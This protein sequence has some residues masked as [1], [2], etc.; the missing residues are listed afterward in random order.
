MFV[1]HLRVQRHAHSLSLSEVPLVVGMA[2]MAPA[3]LLLAQTLGVGM[4]LGFH[5]RQRAFRLA[6]NLAQRFSTTVFAI[7]AFHGVLSFGDSSWGVVWIAGIMAVLLA[8]GLAGVLINTG[9]VLAEGD[10]LKRSER[11]STLFDGVVGVGTVFALANAALGLLTTMMIAEHPSGVLL[12]LSPAATTFL[13]GRAYSKVQRQHDDLTRL[14]EGTGLAQSSLDLETMLGRILAHAREMF[15]ADVA[16]VV[17]FPQAPNEDAIGMCQDRDRPYTGLRTVHVD[18]WEGVTA[19][20]VAQREGVLLARPIANPRLA[21][22]FTRRDIRDAVV[23]PLLGEDEVLGTLLVGNRQGEF[24]TF[25]RDDL[26]LLGTFANHL[27]VAVQNVRLVRRLES[28]L[29][30][31][32]EMSKQKDDFVATI[33][34][35]LRTP[36]TSVQGY[37]KTL[38]RADASIGPH[39]QLEFL[40]RADRQAERLRLLIEELLFAAS[41]DAEGSTKES[42]IDIAELTSRVVEE[43]GWNL[44]PSRLVLSLP[45]DLPRLRTDREHVYRI[46]RNLIENALKYSPEDR[47]VS[48]SAVQADGGISLSVQDE[49]PGIDDSEREKIFE[50]FYQ[51][52]QSSTRS[53]GGTGM[54]LYICRQAALAIGGRVWL[55]RSDSEGSVFSLWLPLQSGA[56]DGGGSLTPGDLIRPQTEEVVRI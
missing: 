18:P 45:T 49:G 10:S 16:E 48:V 32:T 33:S 27:A 36:L 54:G 19:Q 21:A 3:G 4:V 46:V 5:R 15:R 44:V 12:V 34:H 26:R 42:V 53:I 17:L 43:A 40:A 51:V 8:D 14:F 28:S 7:L 23:V 20:A 29:T 39:E 11:A 2:L 41:L 50:R 38:L 13:A 1:V 56:K 31:E 9:I 55:E 52:D 35:E 47:P 37:L 30:H 22:H 25:D 6:F 24:S